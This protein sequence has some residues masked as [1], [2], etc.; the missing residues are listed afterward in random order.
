MNGAMSVPI[1]IF[2]VDFWVPSSL[3]FINPSRIYAHLY[4]YIRISILFRIHIPLATFC[5][6]CCRGT[7]WLHSR[8]AISDIAAL[9]ESHI[10]PPLLTLIRLSL[11]VPSRHRSAISICIGVCLKQV[12]CNHDGGRRPTPKRPRSG[13]ALYYTTLGLPSRAHI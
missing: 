13:V 10:P 3:E 9:S 1:C 7:L 2:H 8:L 6:R 4:F 11:Q 5:C 12:S